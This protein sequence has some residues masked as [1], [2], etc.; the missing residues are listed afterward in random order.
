MPFIALDVLR[1][2]AIHLCH[3]LEKLY[4]ET[5]LDLQFGTLISYM[6]SWY[7]K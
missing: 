4:N 1:E 3:K 6:C 7:K 5:Q 2:L